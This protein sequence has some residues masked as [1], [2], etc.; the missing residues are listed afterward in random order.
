M[1]G[2]EPRKVRRFTQGDELRRGCSLELGLD[3]EPS[4]GLEQ[5]QTFTQA[6]PMESAPVL[7]AFSLGAKAEEPVEIS[8]LQL[9]VELPWVAPYGGS[10]RKSFAAERPELLAGRSQPEG[11]PSLAKVATSSGSRFLI[12]LTRGPLTPRSFA[13]W[14]QRGRLRA[15]CDD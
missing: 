8:G 14:P 2:T 10:E 11:Q 15:R 7:S 6:R 13:I 3:R 5:T 12:W 1:G 9:L 4:I